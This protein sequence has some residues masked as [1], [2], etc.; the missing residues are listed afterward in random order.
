MVFT[1]CSIAANVQPSI[2]IVEEAAEVLEAQLL[3]AIPLSVQHLIMIGDHMQLKPQVH[4]Q[5]LR[6]W[7]HMDLSMFER[8]ANCGLPLQQL[9]YQ[10]RM[11]KEFADLL[12]KLQLYKVPLKTNEKASLALVVLQMVW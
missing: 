8:L 10:C 6:K 5:R 9:G 3:A 12:N 2:M 7:N 11:R 4:H 1:Y